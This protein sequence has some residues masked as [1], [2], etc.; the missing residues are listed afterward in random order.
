VIGAVNSFSYYVTKFFAEYLPLHVGAAANTSK[1]YRDTF[2]QLL[3]FIEDKHRIPADKI[4][5]ETITDSTVED[6]LLYLETAVGVSVSTRNQ[7]LAAVHSFFRYLQKKELSYFAQ[8]SAILSI[9]FKKTSA[10]V[11]SYLS[12][13]EIEILLSI[14][15][16]STR[17]GLRALTILA[18]LYETGA[19]VQELIDLTASN[20]HISDGS[21]YVELRGKGNK[22]RKVP[23]AA[24]AADILKKYSGVFRVLNPGD[25]LFSNSQRGQL[26]RAGVQY[27]V[28]KYMDI[29]RRRE[30]GM[31]RQ[32]ITNHSF[33]H[34]KAMHLLEAGVNLI[35]I[36]DFLGHASVTITEIYAKTNPE[37]KRRLLTENSILTDAGIHYDEKDKEDLLDWLKNNL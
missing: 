34:S 4:T 12:A 25:I 29:A 15:D 21:P 2:V 19:R 11:M 6:F 5:F 9:P 33:R 26:T 8:C 17:K 28:D 22:L 37:I 24:E 10:P 36:R 35:Y 16:S 13:K 27:I 23:I 31:F 30:P 3:K 7:R 18:V 14:P 32:K 20:L 1:S